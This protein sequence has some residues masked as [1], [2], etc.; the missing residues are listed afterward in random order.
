MLLLPS[1]KYSINKLIWQHLRGS[2]RVLPNGS[3]LS[4]EILYLSSKSGSC[5]TASL[6]CKTA[7]KKVYFD[8]SKFFN[9]EVDCKPILIL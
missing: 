8:N 6:V 9:I 1:A 7:L 2:Q 3:D 5:C 4:Q